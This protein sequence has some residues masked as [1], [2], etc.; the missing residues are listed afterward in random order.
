MNDID[1]QEY[2]A[3]QITI[4]QAKEQ[5]DLGKALERLQNN[6]DFQSLILQGYLKDHSARLG[7]LLSDPNMQEK[8]KRKSVIKELEA[9]GNFMGYLRVTSQRAFMAEEAVRVNEEELVNM[10]RDE[11]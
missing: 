11:D 8:S 3:I 2:E 9:V 1:E 4:A 5:I 6:P 10:E 7:H